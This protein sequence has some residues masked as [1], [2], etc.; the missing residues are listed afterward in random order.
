M[1]S[2]IKIKLKVL[3]I[4]NIAFHFRFKSFP[5]PPFIYHHPCTI[6]F[7]REN[8][9]IAK[10]AF[11]L[12]ENLN[13]GLKYIYIYLFGLWGSFSSLMLYAS[14]MLFLPLCF[15]TTAAVVTSV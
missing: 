2:P 7:R 11:A 6:T 5:A 1:S 14:F 12:P 15:K 9:I 3:N 13:N 4:I 10:L 8:S